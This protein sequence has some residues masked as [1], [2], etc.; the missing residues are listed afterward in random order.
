MNEN[1]KDIQKGDWWTAPAIGDKGG[2]VIVTGRKDIGKF[3]SNPRMSIRVEVT[4]PYEPD[5]SGMPDKSESSLMAQAHEALLQ[6][7]DQDPVAV[8]TGVFTG[9]GERTWIFYTASTN[10]FGRKLNE[11]LESL[12][13]LPLNVYCENDPEWEQYD[14][15]SKAEIAID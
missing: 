2:T 5:L 3:R 8:M 9:D 11:S 10:I 1:G 4:W 13:L 15:M 14:E 12:P 6:T 7:F